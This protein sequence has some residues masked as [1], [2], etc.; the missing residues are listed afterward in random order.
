M[1]TTF[2]TFLVNILKEGEVGGGLGMMGGK[3]AQPTAPLSH[4][5]SF[6]QI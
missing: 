5:P 4:F 1:L 2:W 3:W 6:I